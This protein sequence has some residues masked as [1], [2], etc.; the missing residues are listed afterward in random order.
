M[1]NKSMIYA[2]LGLGV[3]I[4]T[5][6]LANTYSFTCPMPKDLAITGGIVY[7]SPNYEGG[8]NMPSDL[9]GNSLGTSTTVAWAGL[10][11]K[12]L[13]DIDKTNSKFS[14][15]NLGGL[16]CFYSLVDSSGNSVLAGLTPGNT[17]NV[18]LYTYTLSSG[19]SSSTDSGT[20]IIAT[21]LNKSK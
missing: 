20:N 21:D 8:N 16:T 12:A 2:L 7:A 6:A 18:N 14:S 13:G 11:P 1:I 9:T 17:Q 10:L 4:S 19:G 3:V 15:V 5:S